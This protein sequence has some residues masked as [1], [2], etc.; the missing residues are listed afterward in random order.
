MWVARF[1]RCLVIAAVA[2][3]GVACDGDNPIGP[4][5]SP[6]IANNPDSFQFQVSNLTGTTQTLTYTWT[7][8]GTSANIDQ[9]GAI[10]SGAATIVLRD[11]TNV[12][13]YSGNLVNTGTF[14]SSTGASGNWQIVVQLT[15]TRG[16]LNFRVQKP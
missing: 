16:T 4:S 10:T 15:N 5:N 13:V 11:A 1:A 2:V 7:N 9:S 14:H 3:G 6:E 8:T 12:Q